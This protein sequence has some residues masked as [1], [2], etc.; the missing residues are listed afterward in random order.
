MCRTIFSDVNI[1]DNNS[2]SKKVNQ[3]NLSKVNTTELSKIGGGKGCETLN[4]KGI[5][6][7]QDQNGKTLD[8]KNFKTVA[9]S[10]DFSYSKQQNKDEEQ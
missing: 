7:F 8:R 2:N 9:N 1:M 10:A 5:A 3:N 4:S 6:G